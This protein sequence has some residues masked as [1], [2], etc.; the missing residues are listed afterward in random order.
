MICPKC[1]HDETLARG[2]MNSKALPGAWNTTFLACGAKM[3]YR[4]NDGLLYYR[5]CDCTLS[6]E[7]IALNVADK[8][9][10][11]MQRCNELSIKNKELTPRDGM[12]LTNTYVANRTL[13]PIDTYDGCGDHI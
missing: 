13:A 2:A 11:T 1:G 3:S 9:L 5:F 7:E 4:G 6:S 8:T 12:F 10:A